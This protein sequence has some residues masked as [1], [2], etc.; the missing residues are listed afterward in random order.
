MIGIRVDVNQVIAT[1]HIKRCLSIALNLRKMGQECLF[2]SAD[3]N[4]IPYV[5]PHGFAVEVLN[6]RWDDWGPE[7][8]KVIR[9]IKERNIHSL[10][11]DS[12]MVTEDFM[13][14][15]KRYT[16]I[17]YFDELYF[18]GYG[19][20]QLINGVLCPPDYSRAE[21]KAFIGPAYVPLREEFVNLQAKS[22]REKIEKILITTGGTD[23]YHFCKAFLEY[24]L[25]QKSWEQVGI[26]VAVGELCPDKDFLRDFYADNDRVQIY[27][28]A[29]NMAQLFMDADYVV[30]AGGTTLYEICATGVAASSFAIADNQL[31]NAKDF[32]DKGYISYAGDFRAEPQLTF[33]NIQLQIEEAASPEYRSRKAE[34]LQQLVDGKGASR[35]A[36]ILINA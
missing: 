19:C 30:S 20:Q 14:E 32:A 10:L 15:V 13:Q 16:Q 31:E 26:I 25:A 7:T 12:Y 4:C 36:Q 2:I 18:L 28:N 1:G 5:E 34:Q 22:I 24:F 17:T 21:G 33:E 29:R 23:N 35:I 6:S 11:V 9:I 8:E 3:E 27:I